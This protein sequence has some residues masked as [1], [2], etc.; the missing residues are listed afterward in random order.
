MGFSQF[1]RPESK[2]KASADQGVGLVREASCLLAVCLH[3]GRGEGAPYGLV[4]KSTNP[5]LQT[6]SQQGVGFKIGI[7]G[8]YR[9]SVHSTAIAAHTPP[10]KGLTPTAWAS[11]MPFSS[12][13]P[14]QTALACSNPKPPPPP[15]PS[16]HSISCVCW[17]WDHL[18]LPGIASWFKVY[19]SCFFSSH[20]QCPTL[21]WPWD[22]CPEMPPELCT[23]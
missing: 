16:S 20:K 4:Y 13:K 2:V 23:T 10:F 11:F 9:H 18:C 12:R 6:P 22:T 21:T 3:G 1:W 19:L 5:H 7:L 17:S 8:R 15:P 14:S